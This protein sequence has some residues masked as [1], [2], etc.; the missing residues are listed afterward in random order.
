MSDRVCSKV[1]A[2][3]F[4][5][6]RHLLGPRPRLDLLKTQGRL[7]VVLTADDWIGV[8]NPDDLEPARA[9]LAGRA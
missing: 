5:F 4:A 9:L 1:E 6:L 8:T 7:D 3:H 2:E